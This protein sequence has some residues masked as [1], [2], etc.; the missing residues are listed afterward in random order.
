[1][2]ALASVNW[3]VRSL[4]TP[5]HPFIYILTSK[6]AKGGLGRGRSVLLTL[7]IPAIWHH[8][9]YHAH[10][11]SDQ[12]LTL[13]LTLQRGPRPGNPTTSTLS[14][15][16]QNDRGGSRS[17]SAGLGPGPAG[18]RGTAGASRPSGGT[19]ASTSA[20]GGSCLPSPPPPQHNPPG[21]MPLLAA[22]PPSPSPGTVDMIGHF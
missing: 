20:Q 9:R 12:G 18:C 16:T 2:L 6:L 5:S 14:P 11:G 21:A 15:N 8:E 7:H 1:M 4:H 3:A 17:G 13:P 10:E 19:S 22:C